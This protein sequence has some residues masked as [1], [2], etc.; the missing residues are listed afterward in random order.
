MQRTLNQYR[1][2]RQNPFTL[3]GR[4]SVA[5]RRLRLE[6]QRCVSNEVEDYQVDRNRFKTQVMR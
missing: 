2:G 1:V 6:V 3:Q 5:R 4:A